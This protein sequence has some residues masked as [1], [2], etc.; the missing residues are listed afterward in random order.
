MGWLLAAAILAI[1]WIGYLYFFEP[2]W[3]SVMLGLGTGCVLACW[4]IDITGNKV[5]NFMITER[6]Q[7]QGPRD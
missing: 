3:L 4:A 6:D 2:D 1:N 7:R 5:P